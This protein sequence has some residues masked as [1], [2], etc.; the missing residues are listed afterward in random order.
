MIMVEVKGLLRA[1][2]ETADMASDSSM[3]KAS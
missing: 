1:P 2:Y 3:G